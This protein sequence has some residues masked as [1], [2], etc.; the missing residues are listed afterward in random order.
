LAGRWAQS[1]AIPTAWR[2]W[3]AA[4]SIAVIDSAV[5]ASAALDP[6]EDIDDFVTLAV[7]ATLEMR[8]RP[9]AGPGHEGVAFQLQLRHRAD[10]RQHPLGV[11]LPI[12]C[13]MQPPPGPN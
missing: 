7:A 11:G 10:G 3:Q 8:L 1:T 13:Q 9:P 2:G 5:I 12:G 6:A 4:C